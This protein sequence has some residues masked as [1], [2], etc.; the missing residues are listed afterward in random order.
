VYAGI[1]LVDHE[2]YETKINEAARDAY[3]EALSRENIA[4]CWII[5]YIP[6]NHIM[7]VA[8]LRKDFQ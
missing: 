7:A 4:L 5:L 3:L 1:E 6:R 8:K 2:D